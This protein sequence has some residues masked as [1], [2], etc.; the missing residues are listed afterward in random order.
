MSVKDRDRRYFRSDRAITSMASDERLG[1]SLASPPQ[2]AF[3]GRRR[4]DRCAAN[5]D[6]HKRRQ[7]AVSSN[8]LHCRKQVNGVAHELR[9]HHGRWRTT[10]RNTPQLIWPEG[11]R[12]VILVDDGIPTQQITVTLSSDEGWVCCLRRWRLENRG[13]QHRFEPSALYQE[14]GRW[15][16]NSER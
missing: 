14:S 13:Y 15:T 1:S 12:N 7:Y 8:C 2:R 16:P 4:N 9:G 10:T 3:R 6:S 5:A 11:F